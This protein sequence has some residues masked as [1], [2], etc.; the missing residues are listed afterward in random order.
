MASGR[1]GTH[2]G[3][4]RP[5]PEEAAPDSLVLRVEISAEQVDAFSPRLREALSAGTAD[6]GLA[7]RE[8]DVAEREARLRDEQAELAERARR[9]T[10]REAELSSSAEPTAAERIRFAHRRH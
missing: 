1:G 6:G 7:R 3:D 4:G 8:L 5:M 10:D 9:L 2:A